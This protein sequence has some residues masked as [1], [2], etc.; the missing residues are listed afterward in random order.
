MTGKAVKK[1]SRRDFLKVGAAAGT[2]AVVTSCVPKPTTTPTAIPIPTP[3]PAP[4][5]APAPA[6]P[7]FD[8]LQF[9]DA[10]QAAIVHAAVGRIIPGTPQDPGA[11][12]AAVVVFI[13]RAL[14]GYDIGLQPRYV[15]GV[16]GMEAY[17]RARY[18]KGFAD[19]SDE[20]QDD[21]L[22]NMQRN[23]GEAKEYLPNPAG[24]FNTLLAHTRQ[25]VFADPIYGGNRNS[26][27]WKLEG[28]PGIVFGRDPSQQKC[29]VDFPKEYMGNQQY[30]AR[31]AP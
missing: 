14:E 21:I 4:V 20:Q 12:E 9:F 10:G 8:A 31:H 17:A 5:P 30:H 16:P 2:L 15:A 13:D 25:G 27:G 11:K 26:V 1:L 23:T 6:S 29:D 7:V 24:F 19:L 28:H 22:S 18:Q 3:T